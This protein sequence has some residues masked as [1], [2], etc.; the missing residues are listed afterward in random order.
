[1][2]MSGAERERKRR[3]NIFADER[4]LA[5]YRQ[6]YRLQHARRYGIIQQPFE[7][8]DVCVYCLSADLEIVA[9]HVIPLSWRSRYG[10]DGDIIGNVKNVVSACR[11]CN[12]SKSARLPRDDDILVVVDELLGF[13]SR[14]VFLPKCFWLPPRLRSVDV[15]IF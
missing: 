12:N 15:P 13:R 4:L 9:D 3:E 7:L 2:A 6:N 5:V 8:G 10:I 1:M 11:P 14:D